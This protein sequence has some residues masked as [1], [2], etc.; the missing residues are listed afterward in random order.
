M[1]SKR[2]PE[3]IK[4]I[5]KGA[6]AAVLELVAGER[7]SDS[8]QVYS[9]MVV[10]DRLFCRTCVPT[11]NRRKRTYSTL[12]ANASEPWCSVKL[13]SFRD[14]MT[15][16]VASSDMRVAWWFDQQHGFQRQL[17]AALK[18]GSGDGRGHAVS[19]ITSRVLNVGLRRM[20]LATTTAA[21]AQF[22]MQSSRVPS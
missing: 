6:D 5:C 8:L 4:V 21:S 18:M 14:R 16:C 1:R 19:S 12:V 17:E 2:N 10:A 20:A 22:R 9:F 7:K 3:T 11:S 13:M 15:S